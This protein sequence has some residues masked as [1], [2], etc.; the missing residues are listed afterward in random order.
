MFDVVQEEEFTAF[1]DVALFLADRGDGHLEED[2]VRVLIGAV[3]SVGGEH[4]LA[5]KKA[6][7]LA[8]E[9]AH[10]FVARR[11]ELDLEAL[12]RTFHEQ[13]LML[14]DRQADLPRLYRELVQ[15]AASDG[16]LELGEQDILR[17]VRN[18]WGLDD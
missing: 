15:V 1:T 5:A 16:E 14:R 8:S 3:A 17:H 12:T 13:C 18:I 2:E 10:G 7:N 9:A 4:G 6:I 11:K